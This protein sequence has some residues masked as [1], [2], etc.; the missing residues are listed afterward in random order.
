MPHTNED[1]TFLFYGRRR[2]DSKAEDEGIPET[3]HFLEILPPS[4]R[5]V[6]SSLGPRSQLIRLPEL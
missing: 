2:G 1:P 6:H 3:I 5:R 4:A